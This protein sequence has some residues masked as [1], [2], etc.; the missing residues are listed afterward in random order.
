MRIDSSKFQFNP[1]VRLIKPISFADFNKLQ[2]DAK[3]VLSD[4]GTITEESSIMNFPA[5]NIREAHERPEGMEEGAVMMVGLETDRILQAI[6][7]LISQPQTLDRQLN[8]VADYAAT[9]VSQK[10]IRIIYSY[11]DYINR[12]IWKK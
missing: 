12:V 7:I 2:L 10:I 6:E 3:A 11:T 8:L 1:L 4:S 5:L 9:N